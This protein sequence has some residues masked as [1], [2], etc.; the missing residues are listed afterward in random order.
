M[1]IFPTGIIGYIEVPITTVKPSQYRNKYINTLIN[2]VVHN[3]HPEL[4]EPIN[5]HYPDIEQI[6]N[7]LEVNLTDLYENP[8]LNKT[9][10]FVQPSEKLAPRAFPPLP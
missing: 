6:N 1:A 9:V 7:S 8:I 5:V 2:S 10:C 4:T 3:Y